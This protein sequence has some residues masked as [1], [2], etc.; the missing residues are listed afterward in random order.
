MEGLLRWPTTQLARLLAKGQSNFQF[1]MSDGR[2]VKLTN[3]RYVL[4]LKK[5]V[6]SLGMLDSK[7]Y[8]YSFS[9][10]EGL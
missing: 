7:G 2:R 10:S 3:V 8:I 9:A 1:R 6:I 4:G 5:N